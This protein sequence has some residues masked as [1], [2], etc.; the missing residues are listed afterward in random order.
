MISTGDFFYRLEINVST[1]LEDIIVLIAGC[2]VL[3]NRG[4]ICRYEYIVRH[5]A[6]IWCGIPVHAECNVIFS[7]TIETTVFQI[8]RAVPGG[9]FPCTMSTL[10]N[11]A[12]WLNAAKGTGTDFVWPIFS[13]EEIATQDIPAIEGCI[14]AWSIQIYLDCIY[15]PCAEKGPSTPATCAPNSVW[16]SYS[17]WCLYQPGEYLL[18]AI[19]AVHETRFRQH[20]RRDNWSGRLYVQDSHHH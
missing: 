5:E 1:D 2:R 7:A 9:Q 8:N 19:Q 10:T 17:M 15:S 4:W 14:R 6:D 20:H 12:V 16:L 11:D 18:R 3:D 13:R